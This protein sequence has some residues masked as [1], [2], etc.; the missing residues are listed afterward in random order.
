MKLIGKLN[1]P[2]LSITL[3]NW[4]MDFPTDRLQTVQISSHTSSIL[5]LNTGAPQGCVPS[6]LQL[7]LYTHD[8]PPRKSENSTVKY[9]NDTIVIG[10]IFNKNES[11]YQEVSIF[12]SG[13]LRKIYRSTSAK[14][15]SW[16]LIL[17]RRGQRDTLLST[18][19]GL[20]WGRSTALGSW[21]GI[22]ITEN[23]SRSLHITSLLYKT[24][25]HRK[26]STFWGNSGRLNFRAKLH[27]V[28]PAAWWIPLC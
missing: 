2:D 26:C 3:C 13:A 16:S 27:L 21:L 6:P 24:L 19:V 11:S 20:R 5:V 10:R 8:C 12:H 25:K 18:W 15:R 22:N 28:T 1:T 14:P 7:T 17:G 23:P 4:I 9:V